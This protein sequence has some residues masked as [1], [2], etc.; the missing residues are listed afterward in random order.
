M[1]SSFRPKDT[2]PNIHSENVSLKVPRR[3]WHSIITW[4]AYLPTKTSPLPPSL[5]PLW[6]NKLYTPVNMLCLI[7]NG[8][9]LCSQLWTIIDMTEN[10]CAQQLSTHSSV[11]IQPGA[12]FGDTFYLFRWR[13]TLHPLWHNMQLCLI[14]WYRVTYGTSYRV[15]YK[16]WCLV[17][18]II[19]V[20]QSHLLLLLLDL[21]ISA[22]DSQTLSWEGRRGRE[23]KKKGEE[24]RRRKE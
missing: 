10:Y 12:L 21:K 8:R 16:G 17:Y 5:P 11:A 14:Q 4:L 23:G 3:K 24:E 19:I 13:I 15:A 9:N 1:W 22:L 6:V 20:S 18:V 7:W 2:K